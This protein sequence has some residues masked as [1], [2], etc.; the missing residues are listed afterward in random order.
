M[1]GSDADMHNERDV[2]SVLGFVLILLTLSLCAI[3]V[4]DNKSATRAVLL[5]NSEIE[6]ARALAKRESTSDKTYNPPCFPGQDDRMS[7]LCAQ[8][9]AAD[10][11][12]SAARATWLFGFLGSGIG[13][14]T[15]FAALYAALYAKEAASETRRGAE[16]SEGQLAL[17]RKL[18]E[19]EVRPLIFPDRVTGQFVGTNRI[20]S[21]VY[22]RNYGRMPAKR[23]ETRFHLYKSS[24]L[25][26]LRKGFAKARRIDFPFCAPAHERRAIIGT[27]VPDDDCNALR[28]GEASIILQ[29]SY[30]YCDDLGRSWSERFDYFARITEWAEDQGPF[31]VLSDL[32]RSARGVR[33]RKTS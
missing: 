23:L 2:F 9:K 28:A 14:L 22:L 4:L 30:S 25:K 13:L 19:I 17:A 11:A 15:F 27:D 5:T 18:D 12:T 6:N 31:F 20:R 8:W 32:H 1:G 33:Q 3:A 29:I 16:A 26:I 24:D 21:T 7:D 10:A